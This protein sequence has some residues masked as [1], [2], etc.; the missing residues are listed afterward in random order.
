M[1]LGDLD[2]DG[3][4]KIYVGYFGVVG[5]QAVSL[6]GKRIWAN[7]TVG[8]VTQ[9]AIGP[10]SDEG[11]SMLLCANLSGPSVE[12]D[13]DGKTVARFGVAGQGFC[14]CLPPTCKAMGTGCGAA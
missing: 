8:S 11:R 9:L 5:V 1:Q 4:P 2:G 14:P 13:A 6:E 12:L 7:R 10:T 3:T